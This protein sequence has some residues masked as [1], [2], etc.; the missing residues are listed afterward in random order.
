MSRAK[1]ASIYLPSGYLDM[2]GLADMARPF[3]FITAARG[4][5]KTYGACEYV[6]DEYTETGG[7]FIFLRRTNT[8]ADIIASAEFSPFAALGRAIA[9]K[10]VNKYTTGV[11]QADEEGKAAGAPM[12]YICGLSTF[13]NVRG[14]DASRVTTIL[15]DEFVP[16][17]HEKPFAKDEAAALWNAYE[18]V[19]RNRELFGLPP[20]RLICMANS[21]RLDNDYFVSLGIVGA[22]WDMMRKGREVR[23]VPERG[24]AIVLPQHS[25]ISERKAETALYKAVGDG[26]FKAMALSNDFGFDA[27]NVAPRR[28]NEYRPLLRVGELCVYE[29]KARMEIYVSRHASGRVPFYD[30]GGEGLDRFKHDNMWLWRMALSGRVWYEDAACKALFD[31][32]FR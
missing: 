2:K 18:T 16:E 25:P 27:S 24:I 32:Y 4:T 26:R 3:L 6:L 12:G 29:H 28:L 22:A 15:Y 23:T 5:G 21:N 10:R 30:S 31:R 19:N 14:F 20:V 13:A 8:Q 9:Q 1:S 7:E 11:Y 17:P